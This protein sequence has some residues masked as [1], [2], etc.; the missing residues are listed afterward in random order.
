MQCIDCQQRCSGCRAQRLSNS[1]TGSR[2]AAEP[3]NEWIGRSVPSRPVPFS[4]P[5][6]TPVQACTHAHTHA[7]GWAVRVRK[8]VQ[9]GSRAHAR[10]NTHGR[11]TRISRDTL[12]C[13]EA[14]CYA[15]Q[16][17]HDCGCAMMQLLATAHQRIEVRLGRS[18][19]P[20]ARDL[21]QTRCAAQRTTRST[22]HAARDT[23]SRLS[24]IEI[25]AH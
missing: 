22:P 19:Q 6:H 25:S 11:H 8:H 5:T 14:H 3:P 16:P 20:A 15:R 2:G 18:V 24:S 4:E 1:E 12:P 17:V 13:C 23:H 7:R 9:R 10:R 21:A